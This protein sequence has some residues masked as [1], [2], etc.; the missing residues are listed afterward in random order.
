M[1]ALSLGAEG[2]YMG[3]RFIATQECPAH[4][5]AKDVIL[6]AA[7]TSTIAVR[8]GN[9]AAAGAS[10]GDRGFVEERRGSIRLVHND[11]LRAMMAHSNFSYDDLFAGAEA[12]EPGEGSNR[13]VDSFLRGNME[14]TTISAGQV[15]GLIRDIPTCRELI[16][17]MAREAEDTADRLQAMRG[18]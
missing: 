9:P 6:A 10:S 2:V 15:A 1:A 12:G 14:N 3:T 7:D 13:T 16:E 4:Q 5:K 11:F 17:R 18:R 8:H